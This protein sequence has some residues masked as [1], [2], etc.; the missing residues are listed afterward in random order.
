V[1]K[2]T[3][4]QFCG[5]AHA[6][7]LVGERWTL[8][9]VRDLALGPQRYSDLLAGLPGIGS[10]L[11]AERLK[12]LEE[13]GLVRKGH[14]PPPA[15]VSVYELTAEGESLYQAMV[16]LAVWGARRL[17]DPD[18]ELLFRADWMLVTIAALFEPER[19]KGVRESYE[20]HIGE[21]VIHVRVDDGRIDTRRG[22]APGGADLVVES[23][24]Q[25]FVEVGVGRL[26]VADAVAQGRGTILSGSAETLQRCVEIL[27]GT[28]RSG[29]E[30][31]V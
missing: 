12:R 22:P 30:P 2:R 4:D 23:D 20:F 24:A 29:A 3:Y 25:T 13:Q 9:I 26:A 19:A 18:G 27:A 5:L 10:G 17:D 16:P 21:E 11:L 15:N 8:L 6:L 31:A 1:T 14:L 28:M 7:D